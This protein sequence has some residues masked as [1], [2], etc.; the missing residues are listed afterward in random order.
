MFNALIHP[1]IGN[2]GPALA[3]IL[4]TIAQ[5]EGKL[6]Q[7]G[8]I[9]IGVANGSSHL[10]FF[11]FRCRPATLD[12]NDFKHGWVGDA[13]RWF[14]PYN[15]EGEVGN[16]NP[17]MPELSKKYAWEAFIKDQK[18]IKDIKKFLL[19]PEGKYKTTQFRAA[20]SLLSENMPHV[21]YFMKNGIEYDWRKSY[22]EAD[23][24]YK[25]REDGSFLLDSK[26]EKNKNRRQ[27]RRQYDI[28]V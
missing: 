18:I 27:R 11:Q 4:T 20:Y 25:T 24:E 9:A 10:G 1:R 14:A 6:G 21:K 17:A 2:F 7:S 22:N 13:L 26:R 12:A 15:T 16:T 3:A 5:R 23:Y 8:N 19:T 28:V